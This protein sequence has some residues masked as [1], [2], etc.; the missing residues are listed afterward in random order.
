LRSARG[1][2]SRDRGRPRGHGRGPDEIGGAHER[3]ARQ[4][5]RV[6]GARGRGS[7]G[8]RRPDH[9]V[10]GR[11][12]L[13]SDLRHDDDGYEAPAVEDLDTTEGPAVT[14]AGNT[15]T[16]TGVTTTVGPQ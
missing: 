6:R 2:G 10:S 7:R 4:P 13:M 5:G 11:F 9:D 1:R 3:R 14:A 12:R 16:P 8:D 15:N